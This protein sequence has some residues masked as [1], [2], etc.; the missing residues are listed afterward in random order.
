M[1]NLSKL[2]AAFQQLDDDGKRFILEMAERKAE[3]QR[4]GNVLRL[5]L[6]DDSGAP[7]SAST[8][9]VLAVKA[10]GRLRLIP[11]SSAPC[12]AVIRTMPQPGGAA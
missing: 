2:I 10:P 8:S 3:R 1:D 4:T 7:C 5:R 9:A 12:A 6:V 11:G